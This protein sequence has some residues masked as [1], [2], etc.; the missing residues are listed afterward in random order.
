MHEMKTLTKT[1]LQ[2]ISDLLSKEDIKEQ[3]RITL[4]SLKKDKKY[5][6]T[7]VSIKPELVVLE[8]EETS[9]KHFEDITIDLDMYYPY[10]DRLEAISYDIE[11]FIRNYEGINY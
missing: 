9:Q 5:N 8:I 11:E 2:K 6:F 10:K 4:S 7:I 3:I 1:K